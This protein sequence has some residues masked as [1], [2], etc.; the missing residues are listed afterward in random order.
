[1]RTRSFLLILLLFITRLSYAQV[2]FTFSA[3]PTEICVGETVNFT[4]NTDGVGG[5]VT[6]YQWDFGDGS[7]FSNDEN[8]SH[9]YNEPRVAGYSVTLTITVDGVSYS[10]AI[11]DYIVV[12]PL[13]QPSFGVSGNS[14]TIPFS[15][16]FTNVSPVG[17][18]Y[19]YQWDFDNG[20]TSTDAQPTGITYG[21]E[22]SY[23]VTLTVTENHGNGLSC[24]SEPFVQ[25]ITVAD[26]YTEF[27]TSTLNVCEGDVVEF[28]DVSDPTVSYWSWNFGG[29]SP[30]TSTSIPNPQ[31]QFFTPGDYD[32]TLISGNASNCEDEFTLTIT[33]SPKPTVDF[34]ADE[35]SGCINDDGEFTVNFTSDTNGSSFEWDF[36]DGNTS[37]EENPTHVYTTEGVF[38]VSLT[39]TNDEGCEA[40][41]T[42][43]GYIDIEPVTAAFEADPINGCDPLDVEFS[44]TSTGPAGD[45]IISWTW[46]LGNGETSTEETPPMQTYN[47]GKYDVSLEVTTANGCSH[48]TLIEEYIEVGEEFD[49]DFTV[50]PLEDCAKSEFEFEATV[51]FGSLVEGVDFDEE[52]ID[53]QW[54][55]GDGDQGNG[56][57]TTHDYPTEVDT[58]DVTLTVTFRGCE[59]EIVKESYINV[60]A[61]IALFSVEDGDNFCSPTDFAT[62]QVNSLEVNFVSEATLVNDIDGKEDHEG[63]VYWW[64]GEDGGTP[65]N[66]DPPNL[67]LDYQVDDLID[68]EDNH[69][70]SYTYADYGTYTV[71]QVV[72]NFETGCS[73]TMSV[74]IVI[75]DAEN[76]FMIVDGS[77]NEI[78]VVCIGQ[79]FFV[80]GS[81]SSASGETFEE[82]QHNYSFGDGTS[83][84]GSID[85]NHSYDDF[86]TFTINF[87][88]ATASC[89]FTSTKSIIVAEP[90]DIVF[91]FSID[92]GGGACTPFE[93]VFDQSASSSPDGF[94]LV[95]FDWLFGIDMDE[96]NIVSTDADGNT[97]HVIEGD[98][99]FDY[100]IA[101]T[102]TDEYGC[103]N[104]DTLAIPITQPNAEFEVD[105]IVCNGDS[106]TAISF[107]QGDSSFV[108]TYAWFLNGELVGTDSVLTTQILVEP[109]EGEIGVPNDL[110]LV[111]TDANGCENELTKTIIVSFP[112]ADFDFFFD[113]ANINAEG[114]AGCPP[115]FATYED[116]S[117]SVGNISV[118]AWDF[119]N[120]NISALQN[121]SNTYF[122]PGTY[123]GALI[124][125]DE[126]GCRDTVVYEDY[127]VI[128]GPTGEAFWDLIGD[129]CDPSYEF[130][131]DSLNNVFTVVWDLGDGTII[132]DTN[133]FV[134]E[135]GEP[136]IYNVTATLVDENDCNLIVLEETI[137]ASG[138][139]PNAS[140]TINPPYAD[141][142]EEVV[143]TDNS[144]SGETGVPI[145]TWAWQTGI[146]QFT[147]NDGT[148]F[149][150]S[151]PEAGVYIVFLT[152]VDQN[153]CIDTT[154]V[155]ILI[156]P[157][158]I[159]PNVFTANNDGVNDIFQLINDAYRE[160]DLVIVNRWG[161]VVSEGKSLTGTYLWD[162]RNVDGTE[163]TEGVYF[164]K[165]DGTLFN[166]EFFQAHGFVTLVRD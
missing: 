143:I 38:D 6:N 41:V 108:E 138:A 19:D 152:V 158:V 166:G 59:S 97:S 141:P 125:E 117:E 3:D 28:E 92:G 55:F 80:V 20:Q 153:G 63:K 72:D 44:S 146:D 25:V 126:F 93:A 140:F 129:I 33:V 60:L 73:D 123:T 113:A 119:G 36:G 94:D 95:N 151:W 157:E 4:A 40:T 13:P 96:T 127:L 47:L 114:E 31:A 137:N 26:F 17:G 102:V 85:G 68:N 147:N 12:Y 122:Q 16:N 66:N 115:V 110:T 22:G 160:F 1:M 98:G 14:C 42:L 82:S 135:Y 99:D 21:S 67:E 27:S 34:S 56:Q 105:T 131:T 51:D 132:E 70:A 163:C 24:A 76:D 11:N 75:G 8:P 52:E 64:F 88:S 116:Q 49:I 161:N 10:E 155:E 43:D 35:T 53:Y 130:S 79:E 107:S 50:D 109:I 121:P 133:T 15:P 150:Y 9:T 23:T 148:P 84:S 57:E 83:Q 61:P 106:I 156:Q 81:T 65:Q 54:D 86:G 45:P 165:I 62:N 128:Q 112:K 37:T 124:I 77:G 103:Q 48:V 32:I 149:T 29:G 39:V 139:T 136:G 87:T 5:N 46:D 154:S 2:D 30:V 111:V 101:L 164:Y 134:H 100:L 118:Y 145:T 71:Y 58:M 144:T 89:S 78:D 159:V 90:A 91:D 74:Q 7:P 18:N 142:N 69:S 120:G 104:S 162:G